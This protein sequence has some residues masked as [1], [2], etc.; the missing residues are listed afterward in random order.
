MEDKFDFS[1]NIEPEKGKNIEE[2]LKG[3][4]HKK[5]MNS[6]PEIK[7]IDKQIDFPT[8]HFCFTQNKQGTGIRGVISQSLA[9]FIVKYFEYDIN[10]IIEKIEI[11]DFSTTTS[12][13]DVDFS[14]I[15]IGIKNFSR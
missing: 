9:N 6:N 11:E 4:I 13:I 15:S 12:L 8:H 14:E 1:K 5:I 3:R 2:I 7:K 10:D